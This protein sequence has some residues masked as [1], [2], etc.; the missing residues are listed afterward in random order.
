MFLQFGACDT[1]VGMNHD[2]SH[3]KVLRCVAYSHVL[4]EIRKKLDK[5]AYKL[6]FCWF[7]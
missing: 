6:C 3:L 1:W 7:I 5:K 2:A 4:E